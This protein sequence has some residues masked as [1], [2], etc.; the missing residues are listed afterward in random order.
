[1]RNSWDRV[2]VRGLRQRFLETNATMFLLHGNHSVFRKQ[3]I[4]TEVCT[5]RYENIGKEY[6][7]GE[8]LLGDKQLLSRILK[9]E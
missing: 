9:G 7:G 1:M 3:E 4:F 5:A 8:R 6:P 2:F